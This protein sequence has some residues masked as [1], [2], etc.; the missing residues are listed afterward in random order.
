ML[1]STLS[2]WLLN[3]AASL[4]GS[5]SVCDRWPRLRGSGSTE[6]GIDYREPVVRNIDAL[7][8]GCWHQL[9]F[10]YCTS[11][12]FL[13]C[14][15]HLYL[16]QQDLQQQDLQQRDPGHLCWNQHSCLSTNTSPGTPGTGETEAHLAKCTLYITLVTSFA[17]YSSCFEIKLL[18]GHIIHI[19]LWYF[20]IKC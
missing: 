13:C 5:I 3:W 10:A 8:C 18:Q 9:C 16:Q 12:A 15:Q 19:P 2:L 14:V 6:H 11:T 7:N 4:Q 17:L 1:T 20:H